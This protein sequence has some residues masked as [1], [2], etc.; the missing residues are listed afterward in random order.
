MT[1]VFTT[2]NLEDVIGLSN[3]YVFDKGKIVMNDSYNYILLKDNE[4]SK[5]GIEIPLMIDLSR[6][7]QF[8]NLIKYTYYDR[9][10]VV[11]ILWKS[12]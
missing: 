1:I 11:D 6:K 3:I 5:M 9:D 10:K 4:L 2:S 8:Y 12:K 7:L